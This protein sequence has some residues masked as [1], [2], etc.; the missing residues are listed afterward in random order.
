MNMRKD[1]SIFQKFLVFHYKN[2]KKK[3]NNEYNIFTNCLRLI[4]LFVAQFQ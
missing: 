3:L 1:F 4:V 2:N